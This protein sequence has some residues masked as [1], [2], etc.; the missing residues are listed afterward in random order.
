MRKFVL[1]TAAAAS[2]IVPLAARQSPQPPPTFLAGTDVVEVDVVVQDK[3]GAFVRDLNAA[4]FTVDED[5]HQQHVDQFYFIDGGTR[6]RP[7]TVTGGAAGAPAAP[8][9]S[10]APPR[11]FVAF[12]DTDHLSN[13]GFKRVRSAATALFS[14]YF[15]DGDLGGVVENGRMANNRLTTARDELLKTIAGLT[16][17]PK[18]RGRRFDE[19]E[20]PRL[21]TAEAVRIVVHD[22]RAV[23]QQAVERACTDDFTLCRNADLAVRGKATQLANDARGET[24]QTGQQLLAVFNGLM[25]FDG[26]KTILLFSEGFFADESWPLVKDAVGQ[27]ARANARVYTF[28]ARGLD[29][30]GMADR[31]AGV[32]PGGNDSLAR[33]ASQFDT[34]ADATTSLAVDTGG[35]VIRNANDFD[36]AVEQVAADAGTYYVLGYHPDRRLDGSFRRLSVKVNRPGVIV[37]ARRGYVATP[38]AAAIPTSAPDAAAP[39]APRQPEALAAPA[40]AVAAPAP[41]PIAPAPSLAPEPGAPERPAVTAASG[42][43]AASTVV[44]SPAPAA[45]TIRV[46]PNAEQHLE[47][48]SPV[49]RDPDA[50][51]GWDA[52]RRGDVES[53]RKSLAAAADRP[54]AATWVHYALGQA[55]YALREFGVATA[56]W[57]RVRTAKPDFEPVYFDLVDAYLQQKDYDRAT[58][59]L[60][61]AEKRWPQDVEVMNALGVV[62]VARGALDDAVRS[63][64]KGIAIAPNEATTYFNLAKTLEL[65]YVQNRRWVPQTKM[66]VANEHDRDDAIANYTRYLGIGGPFENSAR[67]GLSRLNWAKP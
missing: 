3:T 53:A 48:L 9:V 23:L 63:F 12:F 34:A 65:R 20:W 8:A 18:T 2:V 54:G 47:T 28:D 19:Q 26:R 59:L 64:Q 10:P 31:L 60:R 6:S 38:R 39:A 30:A 43:T 24:A 45:S 4:D 27:A 21:S 41:E 11:V 49:T 33:L 14:K 50:D 56:S 66:W 17:N 62:Q 40:A 46:R 7:A 52:Y 37:R 13:A 57:E 35:F 29:R 67:D 32:D 22:D 51:A 44:S 36:K 15:A 25:R 58:R 5:G 42:T 16:P 55:A 1:A 61:D